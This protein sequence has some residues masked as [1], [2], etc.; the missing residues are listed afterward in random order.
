MKP[1]KPTTVY[2]QAYADPDGYGVVE[3]YFPNRY[4]PVRADLFSRVAWQLS[5][6]VGVKVFASMP[7]MAFKLP[8]A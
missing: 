8:A 7:V 2:L 3:V 4:L 1:L 6:R 5:T